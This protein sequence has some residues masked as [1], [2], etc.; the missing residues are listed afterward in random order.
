MLK[1]DELRTSTYWSLRAEEARSIAD[2]MQDEGARDTMLNIA[3]VYEAMA[4]RA[5]KR[6]HAKKSRAQR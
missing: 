2:D 3:N 1:D 6:E 4:D 5:A